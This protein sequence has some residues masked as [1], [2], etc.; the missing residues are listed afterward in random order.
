[1]TNEPQNQSRL[2]A[3]THW[4]SVWLHLALRWIGRYEFGV[5]AGVLVVL[6]G[7]WIF[8]ELAEEVGEGSTADFDEWAVL[9]LREPDNR[10]DPLGPPWLEEIG[11]DLTA[12][13]G[14]VVLTLA[15][16]AVAGFL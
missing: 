10:S 3:A 15:T 7:A 8:I 4:I 1:M 6:A 13:G 16:L 11:R 14:N 12:L 5:L 9:A 2:G